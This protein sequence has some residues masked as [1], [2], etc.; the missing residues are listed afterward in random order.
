MKE[1][2]EEA[3]MS[4]SEAIDKIKKVLTE[5]PDFLEALE[6]ISCC[7]DDQEDKVPDLKEQRRMAM[8]PSKEY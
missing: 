3:M 5:N 7:E 6:A 1:D 4:V 2:K 8:K